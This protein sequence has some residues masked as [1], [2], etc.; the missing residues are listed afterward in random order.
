MKKIIFVITLGLF[1]SEKTKAGEDS[2]IY[3]LVQNII[4]AEIIVPNS[5]TLMFLRTLYGDKLFSDE[6]AEIVLVS[7][8]E[9]GADLKYTFRGNCLEFKTTNLWPLGYKINVWLIPQQ[10]NG[11][12]EVS[13]NYLGE[14]ISSF[15]KFLFKPSPL[16]PEKIDLTHKDDLADFCKY[17]SI[18]AYMLKNEMYIPMYFYNRLSNNFFEDEV[19]TMEFYASMTDI[20]LTPEKHSD[21]TIEIKTPYKSYTFNEK[22]RGKWPMPYKYRTK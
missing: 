10:D 19:Y 22:L 3:K 11:I 16:E 2:T 7:A 18:L 20:G 12:G 9:I 8:K 4:H 17:S 6:F 14:E 1:F 5:E 21:G 13:Y 15:D